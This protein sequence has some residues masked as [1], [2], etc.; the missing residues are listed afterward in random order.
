MTERKVL[1]SWKEISNYTGRGVRT[2]Q[3]YE[4]RLG[5][6]VHRPAGK[7]RSAV[8]AF[9]NEIDTWLSRAPQ[10]D[11]AAATLTPKLRKDQIRNRSQYLAIAANARLGTEK[12]KAT[13]EACQEHVKRVTQ[14]MQRMN[15]LRTARMK[16]S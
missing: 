13:L 1:H 7:P 3:R 5:F 11:E 6:P 9:P 4:V 8:L 10:R 2:I 14:M 16:K 12:A 15:D